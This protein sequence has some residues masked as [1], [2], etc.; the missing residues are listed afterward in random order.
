[1]FVIK[2]KERKR[3]KSVQEGKM[4]F[5]VNAEFDW[6]DCFVE[7]VL[8][9]EWKESGSA[10]KNIARAL[11]VSPSAITLAGTKDKV[12]FFPSLFVNN[13]S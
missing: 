11:N 13:R 2:R 8:R 5:S 10:V 7:F 4:N 12:V 9:K 6:N 3:S 1:M